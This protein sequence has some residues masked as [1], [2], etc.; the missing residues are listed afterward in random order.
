[1]G[2]LAATGR[3]GFFF[4]RST[5]LIPSS[6]HARCVR[7]QVFSTGLVLCAPLVCAREI[8]DCNCDMDGMAGM[9]GGHIDRVCAGGMAIRGQGACQPV[10]RIARS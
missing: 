7:G 8:L 9:V 3:T 6:L 10:H 2:S 5:A 4:L 1:M